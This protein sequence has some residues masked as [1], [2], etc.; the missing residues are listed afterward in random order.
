MRTSKA[1]L[2]RIIR[3]TVKRKLLEAQSTDRELR[4]MGEALGMMAG[5][6]IRDDSRDLVN[7]MLTNNPQDEM[8]RLNRYEDIDG[9]AQVVVEAALSD[10]RSALTGVVVR[11]FEELMEPGR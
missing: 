4:D 10:V 7:D 2:R 8:V 5:E 3:E 9:F 1:Q 11:V 6:L